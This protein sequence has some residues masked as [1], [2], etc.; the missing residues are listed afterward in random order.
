MEFK[1]LVMERRTIRSFSPEPIADGEIEE[2]MATAVYAC[3]SGNQQL[4][5]FI[6]IQNET[7]KNE[8]DRVICEKAAQLV[9]EAEQRN[10]QNPP[11]Y[12]PHRFYLEAPAIV[13]V[14]TTGKYR[15]KPDQL[16]LDIGIDPK[17]VD[18]L[19]CRGDMQTVGAVTQLILLA[20]WEKGLGGCWMTG[21]LYARKE[22][23]EVLK[24]ADGESLAA[25]IPLGKPKIM[26][27]RN[28]RKPLH[29]VVKFIK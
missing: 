11:Q 13:G 5:R 4:W 15:T 23:E 2:I 20:A 16:M 12:A 27:T 26:P 19:R 25:L 29:E 10:L 9:D 6:I 22:L 8:L 24:L 21:P 18:D 1:E 28:S 14:I 17:E 7:L 3:N